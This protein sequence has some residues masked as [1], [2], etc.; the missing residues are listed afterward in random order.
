MGA[1]L[2][3]ADC[4]WAG[5]DMAAFTAQAEADGAEHQ[6]RM[7]RLVAAGVGDGYAHS[8]WNAV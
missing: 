5:L 7:R 3:V 4:Q 1:D 2:R 8:P 6:A